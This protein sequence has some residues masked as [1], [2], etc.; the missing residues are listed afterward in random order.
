MCI[1]RYLHVF[2]RIIMRYVCVHVHV[3]RLRTV[4][5]QWCVFTSN[6]PSQLQTRIQFPCA[7][8]CTCTCLLTDACKMNCLHAETHRYTYIHVYTQTLKTVH[9]H[10]VLSTR[11]LPV[12]RACMGVLSCACLTVDSACA[13][14]QW[15]H[16]SVLSCV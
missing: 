13:P 14:V 4:C 8:K 15:V 3:Y 9:S 1:A 7:C 2:L 6:M 16:T 11:L 12:V 10:H 5:R